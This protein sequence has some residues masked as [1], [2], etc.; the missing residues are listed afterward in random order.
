MLKWS[1]LRTIKIFDVYTVREWVVY[2][3]AKSKDFLRNWI[4]LLLPWVEATPK[5]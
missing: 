4:T 1:I 3:V 5:A 2:S